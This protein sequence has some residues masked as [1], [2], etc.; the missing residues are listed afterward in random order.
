MASVARM[1]NDSSH[2]GAGMGTGGH[3]HVGRVFMSNRVVGGTAGEQGRSG[4]G[5]G[6]G[7]VAKSSHARILHAVDAQRHRA[8][9]PG[10]R[11]HAG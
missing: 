6:E 2:V 11:Q 5:R 3:A 9:A 4:Q 8:T 7:K 10:C 1:I